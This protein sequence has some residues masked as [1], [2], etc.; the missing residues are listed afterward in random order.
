MYL[1]HLEELTFLIFVLFFCTGELKCDFDEKY[2]SGQFAGSRNNFPCMSLFHNSVLS[3]WADNA[4]LALT[5]DGLSDIFFR[6]HRRMTYLWGH[7]FSVCSLQWTMLPCWGFVWFALRNKY[8]LHYIRLSHHLNVCL[9]LWKNKMCF[10]TIFLPNEQCLRAED[11][12]N[13]TQTTAKEKQ[14]K[15]LQPCWWHCSAVR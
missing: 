7:C 13:F 11:M 4:I 8:S 5:A 6:G 15:S 14:D 1:R 12:I 10:G 3:Q 2:V 9:F